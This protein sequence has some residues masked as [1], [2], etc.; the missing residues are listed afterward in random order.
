M[1]AEGNLRASR[2]W[3]GM[4]ASGQRSRKTFRGQTGRFFSVFLDKLLL[5]L[6]SE[7]KE[8]KK[9]V[10]AA[11]MVMMLGISSAFALTGCGGSDESGD[12]AVSYTHLDVY[13]RQ[14]NALTFE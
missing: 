2:V 11:A 12:T 14:Q 7:E 4:V 5:Q 6:F 9:R 1:G 3:K 13:K 10:I 8:M